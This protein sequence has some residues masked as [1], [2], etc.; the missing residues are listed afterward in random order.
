M[1]AIGNFFRALAGR[2]DTDPL[3]QGLW[4]V[5][6]NQAIIRLSQVEQLREM[7][8]AVYLQGPGLARPVLVVNSGPR[9]YLAY[10]N[11]CTHGG[12]KLDPRD[13]GQSLRCCSIS[14]STFDAAGNKTGGPAKG[15]LKTFTAEVVGDELVI[16]LEA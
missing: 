16:S 13:D 1:G 6:G 9:G 7:G 5:E 14:H 12:R 15:P 3:D 2:C 11:R 8:S 4:K 10:E